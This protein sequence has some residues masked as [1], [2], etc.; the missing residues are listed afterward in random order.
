MNLK[1]A[2]VLSLFVHLFFLIFIF[3]FDSKENHQLFVKSG[4]Q[5]VEI[6]VHKEKTK[7][8]Q[9]K[10]EEYNGEFTLL[11]SPSGSFLV[12]NLKKKKKIIKDKNEIRNNNAI[13]SLTKKVLYSLQNNPPKYP[14]MAIKLRLEGTVKLS[15]EVLPKG[16]TGKIKIKVSSGSDLLD[17]SAI[18]AAKQW[19]IFKPNEFKL[20]KSIYID[21]EVQFIL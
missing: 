18:K 14:Y 4:L 12:S 9:K 20:K 17:Q 16:T 1:L 7:K 21:Q 5:S 19:V 11:I 10:I 15:I 13:G 2:F 6:K 8:K 3:Q